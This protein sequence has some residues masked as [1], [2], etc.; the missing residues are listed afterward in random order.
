MARS[1]KDNEENYISKGRL[2]FT[3]KGGIRLKRYLDE[4]KGRPLQAL[5]DDINPINSQ[6]KERTGLPQH[7]KPFGSFR[8]Y[9]I[10]K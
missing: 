6:S 5:W 7:K 9:H 8:A 4:T 3:S 2:H 1:D 10:C